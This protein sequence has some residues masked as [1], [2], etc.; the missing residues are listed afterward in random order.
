MKR[1]SEI[2]GLDV[3]SDNAK[4][5][6]KAHDL[7]LDLQKGEVARITLQPIESLLG[8]SQQWIKENTV[9]YKNVTSVGDIIVVSS[10]PRADDALEEPAPAMHQRP[11][12]YSFV[13]QRAPMYK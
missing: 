10:K 12:K 1:L 5:L 7:V 2:P 13:A 4:I 8:T 3:Y 9:S 11:A 6:G